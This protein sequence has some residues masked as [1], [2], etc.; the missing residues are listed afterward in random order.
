[1]GGAVVGVWRYVEEGGSFL[2]GGVTVATAALAGKEMGSVADDRD[3]RE[4]REVFGG[5]LAGRM[6]DRSGSDE[7][8]ENASSETT[9]EEDDGLDDGT[10][11]NRD[12]IFGCWSF[13]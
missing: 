2:T 8:I 7:S 5:A 9:V 3:W 10:G 11:F 6:V 4:E 1:M 13:L 12:V